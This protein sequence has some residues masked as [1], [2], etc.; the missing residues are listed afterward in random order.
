M[1]EF[2]SFS[3][4]IE[5]VAKISKQAEEK[6]KEEIAKSVYVDSKEF[7]YLD[8]ETMYK[9]GELSDFKKGEV[10]IKGPQVRWLYFTFGIRGHKNPKA[11]PYWFSLTV[12]KYKKKYKGIYYQVFSKGKNDTDWS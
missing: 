12:Q 7:T 1:K 5:W 11:M 8:E 10:T 2:T 4:A 6:S 3:K 9:T